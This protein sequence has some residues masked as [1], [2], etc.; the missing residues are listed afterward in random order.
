MTSQQPVA[1]E[2][3]WALNLS[4]LTRQQGEVCV[5]DTLQCVAVCTR[6]YPFSGAHF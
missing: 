3:T 6:P 2:V 5:R 4:R 1:P